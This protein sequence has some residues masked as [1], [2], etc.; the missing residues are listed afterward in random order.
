[1]QPG[2]KLGH[3]EILAAIGKG[4]MPSIVK[5]FLF[6]LCT[7]GKNPGRKKLNGEPIE[8]SSPEKIL[9]SDIGE[10]PKPLDS[11]CPTKAF[12]GT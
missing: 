12:L 3:S 7:T 2:T 5:G 9:L 11:Q 10:P 1:M 6:R 8:M 4:G